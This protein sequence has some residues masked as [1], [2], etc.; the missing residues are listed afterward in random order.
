M[1]I[2]DIGSKFL[3]STWTNKEL[4][5][6]KRAYGHNS[7]HTKFRWQK[8]LTDLV[9]SVTW[10]KA[11]QTVSIVNGAFIN[12][13]LLVSLITPELP[14]RSTY[15]QTRANWRSRQCCHRCNYVHL[16]RTWLR[17][18]RKCMSRKLVKQAVNQ[19]NNLSI[20]ESINRSTKQSSNQ[21]SKTSQAAQ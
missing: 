10:L 1:S 20:N 5:Q 21:W 3:I 4:R 16:V 6:N 18:C 11:S 9:K 19:P 13:Y 12:V 7:W 2:T 15:L 17:Y 14:Q 8:H